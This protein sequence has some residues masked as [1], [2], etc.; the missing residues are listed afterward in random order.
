MLLCD[1]FIYENGSKKS[2][3]CFLLLGLW[4]HRMKAR[5]EHPQFCCASKISKDKKNNSNKNL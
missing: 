4:R 1:A 5:W 3:D 2:I